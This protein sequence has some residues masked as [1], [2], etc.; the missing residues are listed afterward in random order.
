MSLETGSSEVI[1]TE[2]LKDKPE[3]NPGLLKHLD[4]AASEWSQYLTF[5]TTN[6]V[7]Y[8]HVDCRIKINI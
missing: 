2:E 8:H 3:P 5:T 4:K 7:S 6:A 1:L